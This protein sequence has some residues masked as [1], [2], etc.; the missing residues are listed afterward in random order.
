MKSLATPF[1]PAAVSKFELT[2]EEKRVPAEIHLPEFL[3]FEFGTAAAEMYQCSEKSNQSEE[4]EL[5]DPESLESLPSM[6]EA[7]YEILD[8][9]HPSRASMSF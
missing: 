3:G 1:D 7:D 4:G 2:H 5:S 9:V 8:A 6:D